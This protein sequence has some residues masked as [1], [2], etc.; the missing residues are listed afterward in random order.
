MNEKILPLGTIVTLK[1]GDGTKLMIVTR[2]S[3]VQ[4]DDKEVYFDY[5]SVLTPHGMISPESV[6]FFNKEQ[7]GEVLFKGFEDDAEI[8]FAE[9]YDLM[10]SKTNIPKCQIK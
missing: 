8:Q 5:G 7:V 2:A 4:L 3:I 9:Q 10:I 1:N 6:Y